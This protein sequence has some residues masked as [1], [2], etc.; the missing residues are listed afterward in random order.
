[1]HFMAQSATAGATAQRLA[2][3]ER[4]ALCAQVLA[5]EHGLDGFTMDDLAAAAEVSRRT[6]FNYFPTKVD[7]VLG[8]WPM[9]DEATVATFRAGG[10]HGD[11]LLDLRELLSP[12]VDQIVVD[13]EVTARMRRILN[14]TPRLLAACNDRYLQMSAEIVRHVGKREG[15]GFRAARARIAVVLIASLFEAALEEFLRD[16]RRRAFQHHFDETLRTARSLLGA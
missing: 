4:I 3:S 10:P 1:M 6:V 2:T 8:D 12:L 16:G 14:S 7:A 5:D 15:P 13:R 9:P 11:L